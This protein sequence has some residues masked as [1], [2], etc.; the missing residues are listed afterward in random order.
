MP[1]VT[2]ASGLFWFGAAFTAFGTALGASITLIGTLVQARNTRKTAQIIAANAASM[3]SE[4]LRHDAF[5]GEIAFK[6]GKLEELCQAVD[7]AT[8]YST[9]SVAVFRRNLAPTLKQQLERYNDDMADI[10]RARTIADLYF[11]S[12][13]EIIAKVAGVIGRSL[14]T[15]REYFRAEPTQEQDP[16]GLWTGEIVKLER[17]L[18]ENRAELNQ[19][20]ANEAPRLSLLERDMLA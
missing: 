14:H 6:R 7:R 9:L 20:I 17:E 15:H 11:G 1:D 13:S 4:K 2:Q 18:A 5:L 10:H 8:A 16:L 3:Q 12:L 19:K